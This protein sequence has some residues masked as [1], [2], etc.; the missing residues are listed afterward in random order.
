[1]TAAARSSTQYVDPHVTYKDPASGVVCVIEI[2]AAF[3]DRYEDAYFDLRALGIEIS[4]H[5]VMR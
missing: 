4:R 5:G 1:L 3:W 2:T